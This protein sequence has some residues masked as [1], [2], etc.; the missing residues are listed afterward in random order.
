MAY[1]WICLKIFQYT[2][3]RTIFFL[4]KSLCFRLKLTVCARVFFWRRLVR[5]GAS[6]GS[7]RVKILTKAHHIRVSFN[8]IEVYFQIFLQSKIWLKVIN[9]LVSIVHMRHLCDDRTKKP[10]EKKWGTRMKLEKKKKIEK[11]LLQ[12]EC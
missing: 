1:L 5:G 8:S 6:S 3:S 7:D 9:M 2:N 12:D 10:S 11:K 4:K